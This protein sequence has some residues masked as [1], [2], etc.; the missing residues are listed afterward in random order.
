MAISFKPIPI[1]ETERQNADFTL[2]K[3]RVYEI[4]RHATLSAVGLE[5]GD[6]LSDD[7]TYEIVE[8]YT[9]PAKD[10]RSNVLIARV[11]AIKYQTE[12]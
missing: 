2:I 9:E 12:A 3:D 7:A 1:H 11:T 10:K 4:P 6:T 5:K 8:S